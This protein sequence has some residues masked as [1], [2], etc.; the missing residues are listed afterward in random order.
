MILRLIWL[1]TFF[2]TFS[3]PVRLTNGSKWPF[4]CS[5]STAEVTCQCLPDQKT[6][7]TV[8]L[9]SSASLISGDNTVTWCHKV[10]ATKLLPTR[11]LPLYASIHFN[12]DNGAH[13]FFLIPFFFFTGNP[14]W[15]KT[16]WPQP[17]ALQDPLYSS[18]FTHRLYFTPQTV[19]CVN[20]PFLQHQN[21]A[22]NPGHPSRRDSFIETRYLLM[23]GHLSCLWQKCYDLHRQKQMES[24]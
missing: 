17:R 16:P 19:Y 14:L 1:A 20:P 4:S 6:C 5:L 22:F 9:M 7:T 11:T 18:S 13:T 15:P 10:K 2:P 8:L 12:L 23:F 24:G 3:K 21:L